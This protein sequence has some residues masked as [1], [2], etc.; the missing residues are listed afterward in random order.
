MVDRANFP[1]EWMSKKKPSIQ[2]DQG[3]GAARVQG[4]GGAGQRGVVRQPQR[5]QGHYHQFGG[6][7]HQGQGVQGGGYGGSYG[8]RGYYQPNNYGYSGGTGQPRDWHAN[9]NDKRHTKLKEMM[10]TY[11][12]RT[13]GRVH[14]A[15][16]LQAAGKKQTDLPTLPQYVHPN[17]R[18]FLCWSSVLGRCTFHDCRFLQEGGHPLAKDI[19][20]EFADKVVDTLNK[21]VIA[22]CSNAGQGGSPP[23]KPKVVEGQPTI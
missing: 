9:W 12:E 13:N 10:A 3:Q 8:G 7:G 16:L 22:I 11:L 15:E 20:D 5:P 14:L 19:T 17:G 6:Q 23:K 1:E 18:P 21:G 2:G 4:S